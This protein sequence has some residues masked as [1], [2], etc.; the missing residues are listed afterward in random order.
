M[1]TS[2]LV[3]SI[4]A[5]TMASTTFAAASAPVT[6]AQF[7]ALQK[8]VVMLQKQLAA[9]KVASHQAHHSRHIAKS[10]SVKT[11]PETIHIHR[12]FTENGYKASEFWDATD[13]ANFPLT[14]LQDK[15]VYGDQSFAFGG[16]LELEPINT[17]W[18][19]DFQQYS[20]TGAKEGTLAESPTGSVSDYHHG[21]GIGLSGATIDMMANANKWTQIFVQADIHDGTVLTNGFLTLGNL[22]YTPWY[23][24]IGKFR[25][26]IGVFPGAPW[27]ASIP[28]GI[29]R[30]GHTYNAM[31][32][33]SKN[34]LDAY[35]AYIPKVDGQKQAGMI[36][37][38]YNNHIGQSLWTYSVNA[39][40]ITSVALGQSLTGQ[41]LA[42][43]P[44]NGM[45]DVDGS[46][47]YKGASLG[48]G[49]MTTLK[50]MALTNN[51]K[52]SAWYVDAGY[53]NLK[54]FSK[55]FGFGVNYSA[56]KN[57]QNVLMPLA[58]DANNGPLLYGVK[59]SAFAYMYSR[60]TRHIL[61][62]LEYGRMWTY[63]HRKTNEITLY[64]AF[65]F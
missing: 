53:G 59:N 6:Q 34:H 35:L 2:M 17:W 60:L 26:R 47:G 62:G 1:K 61:T 56:A 25:P 58:G 63:N 14:I 10:K 16:Y 24:T 48:A 18:G 45:V 22:N 12:L 13:S 64:T 43:E 21:A 15:N 41:T 31:L 39:G 8:E 5:A 38:F 20:G 9:E 37:A 4:V 52:A 44:A 7:Q 51:R 19:D 57:T 30:P 23:M 11:T 3:S 42:S 27:M 33:Y 32:G 28:Q 65:Y 49:W 29:F 46:L 54:L 50:N 36:S 55:D 40:Y